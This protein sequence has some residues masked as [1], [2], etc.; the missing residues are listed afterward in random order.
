MTRAPEAETIPTPQ[1]GYRVLDGTE[2]TATTPSPRARPG[3]GWGWPPSSP[4]AG[5][6]TALPGRAAP[7]KCGPAQ[8]GLPAELW[9]RFLRFLMARCIPAA[10]ANAAP[11]SGPPTISAMRAPSVSR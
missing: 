11:S 1:G 4:L 3:T 2:T 10:D 7:P 9:P 5:P 8:F 6:S